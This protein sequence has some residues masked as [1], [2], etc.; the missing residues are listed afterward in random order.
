MNRFHLI[1]VT[2]MSDVVIAVEYKLL[3]VIPIAK[4]GELL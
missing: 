3:R 1:S 4:L 2:Q